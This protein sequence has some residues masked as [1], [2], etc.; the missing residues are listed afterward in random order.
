MPGPEGVMSSHLA[1]TGSQSSWVRLHVD[2]ATTSGL[3]SELALLRSVAPTARI[4][5]DSMCA[6]RSTRAMKVVGMTT[7]MT[8]RCGRSDDVV[9]A[10]W[11]LGVAD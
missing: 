1:R 9:G 5:L 11:I 7:G 4:G 3:A 8:R 2:E 10:M 6:C